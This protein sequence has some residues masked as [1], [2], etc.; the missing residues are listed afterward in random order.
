MFFRIYIANNKKDVLSGIAEKLLKYSEK[1]NI[2]VSILEKGETSNVAGLYLGSKNKIE[3]YGKKSVT[4][5]TLIHEIV[6][7]LSVIDIF[8]NPDSKQVKSL[9]KIT[10]DS[11]I[12]TDF[13]IF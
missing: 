7:S 2:E 6:H 3:I 13:I 9:E 11:R 4:S 1:N 10:K 12:K 8:L 5:H